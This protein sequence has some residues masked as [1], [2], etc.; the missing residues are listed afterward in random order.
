MMQTNNNLNKLR[1]IEQTSENGA[2]P[3]HFDAVQK[4]RIRICEKCTL[5]PCIMACA[6]PV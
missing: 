4:K 5:I 1:N 6:L 2:A 3:H